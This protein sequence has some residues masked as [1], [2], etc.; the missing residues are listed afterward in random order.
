LAVKAASV[1]GQ[2]QV[3]SVDLRLNA[4]LSQPQLTLYRDAHHLA[5]QDLP[6]AREAQRCAPFLFS[7]QSHSPCASKNNFLLRANNHL[8]IILV[9]NVNCER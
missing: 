5:G 7:V 6:P 3:N 1:L 2:A 9:S 4:Q 8:S